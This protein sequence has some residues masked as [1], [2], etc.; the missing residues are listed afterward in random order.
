MVLAPSAHLLSGYWKK[1]Q[2]YSEYNCFFEEGGQPLVRTKSGG[3]IVGC[4]WNKRGNLLLLPALNWGSLP[5]DEEKD[6][7]NE[8]PESYLKFT[9]DLRDAL[10]E[11][12]NRLAMD[13]EVTP[14]PAW[15]EAP[16]FRLQSEAALESEISE[17]ESRIG[18]LAAQRA[19]LMNELEQQG[20]LRRLLFEGGSSLEQAVREALR[21]LGFN[22]SNFKE[23]DTEF[24][25]LFTSPEGRFLGEVEGKENKPINVDK[26]SQLHRNISEDFSREEVNEPALPVLFG[27]AFRTLPLQDRPQF[28][29]EKVMKFASTANIALVRTTDLFIVASYV[30]DTSDESFARACR[31]AIKDGVGGI[32]AFPEAPVCD[33]IEIVTIEN[34]TTSS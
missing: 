20:A 15:V 1:F 4:Y 34:T 30:K 29:T 21:I 3:N 7:A 9:R 8:W 17:V 31:V 13:K 33:R 16:Q 32:V 25:A 24:D 23:E 12:D 22:A 26:I 19:T 11:L 28:F 27:N 6:D 2:A 18:V 5:E 10:I 14:A